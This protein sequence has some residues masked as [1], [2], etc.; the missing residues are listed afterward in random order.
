MS[1][2]LSSGPIL[3]IAVTWTVLIGMYVGAYYWKVD[4]SLRVSSS[5]VGWRL[6]PYYGPWHDWLS[7]LF[8]PMHWLD[9]RMRP[10]F[11]EGD[12]PNVYRTH[13]SVI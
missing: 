9:R 7:P 13:G 5:A 12:H 3:P 4:A 6:S 2:R 11:W 8:A 1:E 10:D